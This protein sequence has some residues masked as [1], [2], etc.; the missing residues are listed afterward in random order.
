MYNPLFEIISVDWRNKWISEVNNCRKNNPYIVHIKIE[1][2]VMKGYSER[3][4]CLQNTNPT[5]LQLYLDRETI[6]YMPLF[7]T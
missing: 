7:L 5:G 4:Q 1:I 3:E 6:H 2:F